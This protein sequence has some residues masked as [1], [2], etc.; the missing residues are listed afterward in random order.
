MKRAL[1][2]TGARN[3][4]LLPAY[5]AVSWYVAAASSGASAQ[6]A[7]PVAV[8]VAVQLTDVGPGASVNVTGAPATAAAPL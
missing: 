5:D 4:T 1:A 8:V 3:G 7:W 6:D 2:L